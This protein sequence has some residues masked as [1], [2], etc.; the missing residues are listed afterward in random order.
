M[1][2][3]VRRVTKWRAGRRTGLDDDGVVL[4][5]NGSN[6]GRRRTSESEFSLAQR[7]GKE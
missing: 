2:C 1:D 3:A 6:D 4:A 5:D 7:W